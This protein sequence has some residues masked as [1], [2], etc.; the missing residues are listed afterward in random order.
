VPPLKHQTKWLHVGGVDG[1]KRPDDI[2][3]L[4]DKDRTWQ[5]E[6]LLN[7]EQILKRWFIGQAPAP[8]C[9]HGVGAKIFPSL[10]TKL[11]SSSFSL[12]MVENFR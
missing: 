1:C 7:F 8:D 10:V 9:R 3:I 11:L 2:P 6:M 4:F 5:I 12:M